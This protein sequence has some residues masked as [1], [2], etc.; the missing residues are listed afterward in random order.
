MSTAFLVSLD[1]DSSADLLGY[2][3]K[4][5]PWLNETVRTT[6]LENPPVWGEVVYY[7]DD[8]TCERVKDSLVGH[9]G[10]NPEC[11]VT[12]EGG[13][14]DKPCGCPFDEALCDSCQKEE[15]DE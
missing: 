13:Q 5:I 10:Y 15:E 7:D 3:I 6:D 11:H 9:D 2:P 4:F 14:E 1:N 12:R 8:F